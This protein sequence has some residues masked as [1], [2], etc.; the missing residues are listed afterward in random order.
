MNHDDTP[1]TA[2]APLGAEQAREAVI[3]ALTRIVPDADFESIGPDT[4]LRAELEL[5]SRDFLTFVELLSKHTGVRID[6]A[7]YVNLRTMATCTA[8]LS[9]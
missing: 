8:F 5:D 3:A 1:A 9:G 7:D 6:E 2:R 4:P